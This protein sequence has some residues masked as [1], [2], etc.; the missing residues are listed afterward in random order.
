MNKKEHFLS[1]IKQAEE[2]IDYLL[3]LGTDEGYKAATAVEEE[4]FD[5][6]NDRHRQRITNVMFLPNHIHFQE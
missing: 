5:W 6:F 1:L 2:R 3:A 4:Y